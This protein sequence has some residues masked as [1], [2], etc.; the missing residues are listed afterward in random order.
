MIGEY[1]C[2]F[3]HNTGEICGRN[4]MCPKGCSYYWK[5]KR[6]VPCSK[7]TDSTSGHCLLHI[8][9]Y[10]IVWYYNR[11]RAKAFKMSSQ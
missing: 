6:R 4:S 11:L 9:G 10:Y 1:T 3:Y 7:P 8:R 2:P 5:A